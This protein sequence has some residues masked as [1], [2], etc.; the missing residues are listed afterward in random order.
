MGYSTDSVIILQGLFLSFLFATIL[1]SP[2]NTNEI[3]LRR[4][5]FHKRPY[6]QKVCPETGITKVHTNLILLQIESVDEK[7][8]VSL[9]SL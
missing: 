4:L 2:V 5:L 1:I 6:D 9:F 3:E 7:A 8:Q